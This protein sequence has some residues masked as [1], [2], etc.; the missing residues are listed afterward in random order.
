MDTN[1][2]TYGLKYLFAFVFLNLCA[3]VDNQ[4]YT[5]CKQKSGL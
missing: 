3:F 2:F 4:V 5:F 1:D